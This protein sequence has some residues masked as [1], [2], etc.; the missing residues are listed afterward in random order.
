MPWSP[1]TA[2]VPLDSPQAL[3][4]AVRLLD[5]FRPGSAV[6]CDPGIPVLAALV[7]ATGEP[8]GAARRAVAAWATTVGRGPNHH[9]LYDSGLAGTLVGL[10]H[11]AAL[12]PP[13]LRLAD[14]VRGHLL[15]TAGQRPWRTEKV[16]LPDYDLISGP[17]GTLLAL[18]TAATAHPAPL[19]DHLAALCDSAALPRLRTGGYENDPNLHWLHGRI[20]TGTGHGVAGLTM[21]LTAAVRRTGPEPR[22]VRA[23]RHAVDWLV[24]QSFT[25]DRSVRSWDGAG[26][27]GT[28]PAPG[29]RPRQAWCYGNPGITWALW[30]AA[31]ALG[32]ERT[33]AW[34][35]TAFATLADAYDPD[36]HLYGELPADR[37]ALC[38]GAAGVLAVADAFARHARLSAAA[39]LRAR[40]LRHLESRLPELDEPSWHHGLLGGTTGVLAAL[41]TTGHGASRDWLPCLGLR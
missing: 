20:N 26:H 24:R 40:L 21:A 38:H 33:A 7:A 9:A 22:F 11:A 10:H 17:A 30:D 31:D 36:Y 15:T 8:T 12:H 35:V 37:L 2:P 23:L 39:T 1:Q 4:R 16:T 18:Y 28:P 27:D 6:A 14:R 13:L 34:A 3:H 5:E 25:D 41:L 29:P 32:D 19:A